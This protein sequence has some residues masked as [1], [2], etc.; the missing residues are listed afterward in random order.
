HEHERECEAVLEYLIGEE[1]EIAG[2]SQ[3]AEYGV[4][5]AADREAEQRHGEIEEEI[6][7]L[8]DLAVGAHGGQSAPKRSYAG[9]VQPEGVVLLRAFGA[10]D[11]NGTR[12]NGKA[13]D[14][15][16]PLPEFPIGVP[17]GTSLLVRE[18]RVVDVHAGER[19]LQQ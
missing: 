6:D 16:H 13:D 9:K 19:R 12:C 5:A 10:I 11:S 2:N 7:D 8:A 18:L 17:I 4:N 14:D 1:A 3:C 15:G